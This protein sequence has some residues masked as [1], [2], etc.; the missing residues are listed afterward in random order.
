M[1]FN[2][3]KRKKKKILFISGGGFRGVYA[4]GIL[5]RIE[6][7]DM[8]KDIIAIFGVSIGSVIGSVRANGMSAQ[9]IYDEMEQ[10]NFTR[11]YAINILQS[12]FKS[13]I[14]NGPIQKMISSKL[15]KNI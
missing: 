10:M 15:P 7:L 5:K 4:L 13:L 14:S 2:L 11:F 8:K 6:E 1:I 3:F 12:G 9:E